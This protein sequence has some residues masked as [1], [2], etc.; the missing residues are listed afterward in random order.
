MAAVRVAVPQMARM[1]PHS[2]ALAGVYSG[3]SL[4]PCTTLSSTAAFAIFLALL[5]SQAVG[6]LG[7]V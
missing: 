2:I 4:R 3:I 1:L 7:G 6:S 5:S